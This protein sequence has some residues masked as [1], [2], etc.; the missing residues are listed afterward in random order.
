M[1]YKSVK[2]H[3]TEPIDHAFQKSKEKKFKIFIGIGFAVIVLFIISSALLASFADKYMNVPK[4]Y[5][6]TLLMYSVSYPGQYFTKSTADANPAVFIN[7]KKAGDNVVIAANDGTEVLD[8]EMIVSY[9]SGDARVSD[10]TTA[11]RSTLTVGGQP[12]KDVVVTTSMGGVKVKSRAVYMLLK[13]GWNFLFFHTCTA[14]DCD[15]EGF[16]EV[17]KGTKFN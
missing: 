12:A 14:S 10:V 16:E 1:L 15:D 13:D 9:I 17:L 8:E 2:A 3:T 4:Q 5:D 11:S 6:N 7:L